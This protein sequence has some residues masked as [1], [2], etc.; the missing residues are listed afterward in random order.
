MV[1]LC[2]K[3]DSAGEGEMY[4]HNEEQH[5][6]HSIKGTVTTQLTS[7][8]DEMNPGRTCLLTRQCRAWQSEAVA[9]TDNAITEQA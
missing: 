7:A 4:K 2:R 8:G 5:G 1:L 3:E 9:P 6:V